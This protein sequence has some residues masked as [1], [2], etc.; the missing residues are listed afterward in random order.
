MRALYAHFDAE[1][2]ALHVRRMEVW[3]RDRPQNA[4]GRHRYD[5]AD[6]GFTPAGLRERF[7]DYRER[8]GVA[9]AESG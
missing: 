9:D 7:A 5:P 1:P 8:F 3:M 2:C 6:F 4:F